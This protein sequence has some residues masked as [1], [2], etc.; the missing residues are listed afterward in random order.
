MCIYVLDESEK[1]T[2]YLIDLGF[3]FAL[4]ICLNVVLENELYLCFKLTLLISICSSLS[5]VKA[6]GVV[7]KL[8]YKSELIPFH[9]L[10]FTQVH[11]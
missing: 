7:K 10:S 3:N 2:L 8:M 9:L 4:K 1:K 11:R 5:G 6:F